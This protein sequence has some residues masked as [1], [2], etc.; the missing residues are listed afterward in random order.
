MSVSKRCALR[1]LVHASA[2][3]VIESL[4]QRRLLTAGAFDPAFAN[5]GKLFVPAASGAHSE[6]TTILVQSDG[7]VLVDGNDSTSDHVEDGTLQ[8]RLTRFN[9]DGTID[10]SFAT[11]GARLFG[12]NTFAGDIALAGNGN[13]VIA[14]NNKLTRLKSNGKLDTTFGSKGSVSLSITSGSIALSGS[15]I[16]I[17]G[18]TDVL[19]FNSGGSIDKGFGRSGDASVTKLTGFNDLLISQLLRQSDGKILVV[20]ERRDPQ[21]HAFAQVIA[22]LTNSGKLDTTFG[23]GKGFVTDAGRIGLAAAAV[24]Q[25]DGKLLVFGNNVGAFAA[26]YNTNGT[27]DSLFGKKGVSGLSGDFSGAALQ[28]DHKILVLSQFN[29]SGMQQ[30]SLFI[31]RL[32]SD[33]KIDSSFGHKGVSS[34]AIPLGENVEMFGETIAVGPSNRIYAGA[35]ISDD[36][37]NASDAVLIG[38]LST[39][40]S[41]KFAILSNGTLSIEGTQGDNVLELDEDGDKLVAYRDSEFLSFNKSAVK[42]VKIDALG[43]DDRILNATQ[44]TSTLNGGDGSDTITS[45]GGPSTIN[46]DAGDDSLEGGDGPDFINGGDGNDTMTGGAGDDT[47]LGGPGNDLFDDGGDGRDTIDYSDRTHPIQALVQ[48]FDSDKILSDEVTIGNETDIIGDDF[49]V[50]IGTRFDDSLEPVVPEIHEGN[51]NDF[52]QETPDRF[53]TVYGEGGNDTFDGIEEAGESAVFGGPGNDLFV[54]WNFVDGGDGYDVQQVGELQGHLAEIDLSPGIEELDSVGAL[55]SQR[56]VGNDLSNKIVSTGN[57]PVTLLGM[58]GNDTLIGGSADDSLDGG[59]GNDT[60]HGGDGNDTLRGGPGRDKL[61]GDSGNDL[62]LAKLGSKDIL[63]GGAGTDTASADQGPDLF[64][65][66]RNIEVVR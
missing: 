14:A 48:G 43:G 52:F 57:N 5:S 28:T 16:A 23:N 54:E 39:N 10:T 13:I 34:I 59:A 60:L 3:S 20:G 7:K 25:S 15:K 51:G 35:D 27:L 47:F 17:G 18:K 46:G 45:G 66:L 31:T 40:Q 50:L 12:N 21:F 4:E 63:D 56:V 61:F 9:V 53:C 30:P 65:D 49:E 41:A 55:R 44:I 62:L 37:G 58:G 26:R 1:A 2:R 11:N 6:V 64:D 42:R 38:L 19:Q 36:L 22:R 33:G 29:A 8:H 32:N 24:L